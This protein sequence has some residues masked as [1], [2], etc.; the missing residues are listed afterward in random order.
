MVFGGYNPTQW[1]Q[2]EKAFVS[3]TV[4]SLQIWGSVSEGGSILSAFD[5]DLSL[6]R[7][8]FFGNTFRQGP[9]A[10]FFYQEFSQ[11][12]G[13]AYSNVVSVTNSGFLATE[14]SNNSQWASF[15]ISMKNDVFVSSN[16][17][18]ADNLSGHQFVEIDSGSANATISKWRYASN[19]H[20]VSLSGNFIF[21]DFEVSD[22]DNIPMVLLGGKYSFNNLHVFNHTSRMVRNIITTT[23]SSSNSYFD[24]FRIPFIHDDAPLPQAGLDEEAESTDPGDRTIPSLILLSNSTFHDNLSQ[25]GMIDVKVSTIQMSNCTFD[26]NESATIGGCIN[27]YARSIVSIIDC[28]FHNNT[29]TIV[30]GAVVITEASSASIER[31]NFTVNASDKGGALF[32]D[33]TSEFTLS[34]SYFYRNIANEAGGAISLESHIATITN[35][36]FE[37]NL[38]FSVSAAIYISGDSTLNITDCLFITNVAASGSCLTVSGRAVPQIRSSIFYNNIARNNG[39]CMVARSSSSPKFYNCEF[40]NNTASSMGGVGSFSDRSSPLFQTCKFHDNSSPNEAGVLHCTDQSNITISQSNFFSNHAGSSGGVMAIGV[41]A[42]GIISDSLFENNSATSKGGAIACYNYCL[43]TFRNVTIQSNTATSGAGLWI[44]DVATPFFDSSTFSQNNALSQGGAMLA[45]DY[46]G[47]SFT[48]CLFINNQAPSGTGGAISVQDYSTVEFH[49]CNFTSNIAQNGAGLY[50]VASTGPHVYYSMFYLNTAIINGGAI[51]IAEN[52]SASFSNIVCLNNT[53]YGSGGCIFISDVSY[54]VFNELNITNNKAS[55]FGGGV[56]IADKSVPSFFGCEFIGNEAS[57]GGALMSEQT[58]GGSLDYGFFYNNKALLFGGG[59]L[60]QA[61]N[62]IMSNLYALNNFA[63]SGGAVAIEGSPRLLRTSELCTNCSFVNNIAN[64]GAGLFIQLTGGITLPF[65]PLPPVGNGSYYTPDDIHYT[66]D[67]LITQ[68]PL[69]DNYT[70]FTQQSYNNY[71]VLRSEF[72]QGL[73]T[74]SHARNRIERLSED[75]YEDEYSFINVFFS[76]NLA[77][78]GSGIYYLGNFVI[79]FENVTLDSNIALKYGG[80]IYIDAEESESTTWMS[81]STF[82]NNQAYYGGYNVGFDTSSVNAQNFCEFCSFGESGNTTLG[83][84]NTNGFAT[85]PTSIDFI[86]HC[87]GNEE[88]TSSLFT[89]EM[90][91]Y[92]SFLTA[93][94]GKILQD[95]Q[96]NITVSTNPNCNLSSPNGFYDIIDSTTGIGNFTGMYLQGKNGSQCALHYAIASYPQPTISPLNCFISLSGCPDDYK[97]T[98]ADPYDYCVPSNLS[99]SSP[100][101]PL[102]FHFYLSPPS[103]HLYLLSLFPS[104]NS[105]FLLILPP[106][107]HSILFSLFTGSL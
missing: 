60:F 53:A 52:C 74:V 22:I 31:S 42:T 67:D 23:Q 48:N 58:S 88:L 33:A 44:T 55:T 34:D 28:S 46:G 37:E 106:L 78:Y 47:G 1:Y 77:E 91:L 89:I 41:N 95:T 51:K 81:N 14:N 85:S 96:Y 99:L 59:I 62:L 4:S 24:P 17:T 2:S 68:S 100:S 9:Y 16:V 97:L 66:W 49:Y 70:H 82:I 72:Q 94:K 11:G 64:R 36:V 6:D 20:G 30:G 71:L 56:C 43:P 29:S 57:S 92:D 104:P 32:F 8:N 63:T 19:S 84:A 27:A 45:S 73:K 90:Q 7:L 35:S 69:Y 86:Q 79:T 101:F 50:S 61:S 21:D 76:S 40:Y 83:Y 65:A 98:L 5:M 15:T 87:P 26:S 10:L 103:H 39:G 38:S 102:P 18:F 12:N 75:Y 105:S 80:G 13:N 3:G 25:T 93:V 107:S 54:P